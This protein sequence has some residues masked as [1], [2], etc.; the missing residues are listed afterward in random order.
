[1]GAITLVQETDYPWDG[2][3]TLRI[4][5]LKGKK[6]I[7]FRLRHPGWSK[8]MQVTASN[9]VTA[10]EDNGYLTLSGIWRQGD[11]ITLDMPMETRIVEANP[12]VEEARGQV[13]IQRGPIVYCAESQDLGGTD[14]DNIAIP[15]NA[16]FTPV[17]TNIAGSRIMALEGDVLVR[18]V[19]S[20]E[21]TL[22]R[23]AATTQQRKTIRLIPYYA[24]GNRGTSE[25]TVWIP[26]DY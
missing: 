26:A 17:E 6:T 8:T 5:Q 21:G 2:K 14:I 15:V 20:W 16:R 11:V 10:T 1:M 18:G 9:G 13:A 4:N 12:L 25:M 22:Y 19:T 3:V 23:D 7:T 24:W